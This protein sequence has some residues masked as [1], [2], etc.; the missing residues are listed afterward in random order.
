MNCVLEAIS[1]CVLAS[2]SPPTLSLPHSILDNGVCS[3]RNLVS[4]CCCLELGPGVCCSLGPGSRLGRSDAPDLRRRGHGGHERLRPLQRGRLGQ[5]NVDDVVGA[6][7]KDLL[8]SVEV[9]AGSGTLVNVDGAAAADVEDLVRRRRRLRGRAIMVALQAW[10]V[11][12]LSREV[13]LDA[14][15]RGRLRSR[16]VRGSARSGCAHGRP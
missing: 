13:V 1:T 16:S 8:M 5:V 12:L 10:L 14:P 9:G 2:P 3:V 15:S 7:V 6:D 11:G 4:I